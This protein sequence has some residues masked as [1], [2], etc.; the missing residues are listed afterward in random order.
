MFI[1]FIFSSKLIVAGFLSAAK[2]FHLCRVTLITG[3]KAPSL[4]GMRLR[5]NTHVQLLQ[6][7]TRPRHAGHGS[8][9]RAQ[10]SCVFCAR[11]ERSWYR[12]DVSF[13]AQAA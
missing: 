9:L 13:G 10:G 5:M 12:D 1:L 7:V 4:G 6:P 8:S 3:K 2:C 11:A